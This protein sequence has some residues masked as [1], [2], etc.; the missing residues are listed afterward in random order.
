MNYN[1][2]R[3]ILDK[4]ERKKDGEEYVGSSS[5]EDACENL[6]CDIKLF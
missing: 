2:G 4:V 1:R 3:V 5:L 6:S